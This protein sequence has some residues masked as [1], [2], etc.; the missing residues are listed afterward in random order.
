MLAAMALGA[1]G[2]QIGSRFVASI[3]SSAHDNFKLKV[4]DSSEDDTQLMLKK[5]TPVRLLKN[6]FFQQVKSAEEAG[7]SVEELT[8]L[9]G[10][11]RS[12]LGMFEGDLE[13]GELEIGQ[14]A[15]GLDYILPAADIVKNIMKEY[16]KTL[17]GFSPKN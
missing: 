7:A 11:G 14:V 3:E 12:K 4:L 10:K 2:V 5:L 1:E 17:E 6:P 8:S 9:L 16:T 15:A 13:Q